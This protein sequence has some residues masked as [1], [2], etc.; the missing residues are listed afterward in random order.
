MNIDKTNKITGQ[1]DR[2]RPIIL[3][4]AIRVFSQRGFDGGSLREIAGHAGV[5]HAMI[6][7]YFGSKEQLWRDAVSFLFERQ[8]NELQPEAVFAAGQDQRQGLRVLCEQLIRYWARH[9]EHGRLVMQAS[10]TPGP[11]LDWLIHETKKNHGLFLAYFGGDATA[12]SQDNKF[13]TVAMLYL[14]VGACQTVFMLEHEVRELYG[15]DVTDPAFIDMFVKLAIDR[16]IPASTVDR[17]VSTAGTDNI[18]EVTEIST[19]RVNAR[20]TPTGLE[21]NI[22]IPGSEFQT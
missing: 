18:D 10:M 9:P 13:A 14:L 5:S 12:E 7:Y 3:D 16:L 4:S 21:L 6:K 15:V 22:V 17:A 8:R 2:A 19:A 1:T 20:K 11:C